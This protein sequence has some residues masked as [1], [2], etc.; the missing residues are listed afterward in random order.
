MPDLDEA[1]SAFTCATARGLNDEAS[2]GGGFEDDG[3]V[4]NVNRST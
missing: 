4:E 3:S 1:F 2:P